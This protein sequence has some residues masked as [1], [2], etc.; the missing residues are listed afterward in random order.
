MI[1]KEFL[2]FKKTQNMSTFKLIAGCLLYA[3]VLRNLSENQA[4]INVQTCS[5]QWHL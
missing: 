3:N 1:I 2:K 4:K 5:Q